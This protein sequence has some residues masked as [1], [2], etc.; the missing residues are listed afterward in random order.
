MNIKI[1]KNRTKVTIHPDK[2]IFEYDVKQ[3]INIETVY[4][5]GKESHINIGIEFRNGAGHKISMRLNKED[6]FIIEDVVSMA[7][8]LIATNDLI[9]NLPS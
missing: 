8:D 5:L 3:E 7:C 1:T 9:K 2:T 6:L 4:V